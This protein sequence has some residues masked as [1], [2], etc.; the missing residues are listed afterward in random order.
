MRE[1]YRTSPKVLYPKRDPK[2]GLV[3]LS[4]TNTPNWLHRLTSSEGSI[5]ASL[6]L[7]HAG[8]EV[9]SQAGDLVPQVPE[10]ALMDGC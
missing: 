8:V 5:E 1:L 3:R 10:V 4:I 6:G 7:F 9:W 2:V